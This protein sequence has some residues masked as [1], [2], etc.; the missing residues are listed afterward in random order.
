M[1][2]IVTLQPW[3]VNSYSLDSIITNYPFEQPAWRI[4][5]QLFNQLLTE[6]L[7]KQYLVSEYY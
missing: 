1:R 2:W 4:I 3:L 7:V 5:N 6:L